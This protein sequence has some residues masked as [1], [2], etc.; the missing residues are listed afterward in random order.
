MFNTEMFLKENLIRGLANGSFTAEQVGIYA[1]NYY[2]KGD[3][4]ESCFNELKEM[5]E[6]KETDLEEIPTVIDA[7][8]TEENTDLST[9]E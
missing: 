3:I 2:R 7:Q 6:P 4:S 1:Y 9:N 8:Y 5:V